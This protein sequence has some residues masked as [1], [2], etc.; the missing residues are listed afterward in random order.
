MLRL[1]PAT[2]LQDQTF[3]ARPE[4]LPR[5]HLELDRDHHV[6]SVDGK[7]AVEGITGL[8]YKLVDVLVEAGGRL[9]ANQTIGD[10]VWGA[11]LWDTYMLHNLVRRVRRKLELQG[12]PADDLIVS[13]PGSGY[14]A[15]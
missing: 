13:V 9:V 12:L 11:G 8:E 2:L 14:R 5:L 7:P 1:T 15:A 10:T 4:P 6:L 3:Q